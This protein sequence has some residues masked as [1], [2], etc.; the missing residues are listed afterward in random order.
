M[1]FCVNCGNQLAENQKFCPS[2]GTATG[3]AIPQQQVRSSKDGEVIKCPYCGAPANPLD[4][5]CPEC[6]YEFRNRSAA[7][8]VNDFF[9]HYRNASPSEKAAIIKAFPIPNAKEDI[10]TFLAMGIGNTKGLTAFEEAEYRN[11]D[12]IKSVL[13]G[14][15]GASALTY[16]KQEIAAWRAKVQ[17]VLDIGKLLIKDNES[18]ALFQK[19]EKQLKKELRK[20]ALTILKICIG[21]AIGVALIALM[22]LFLPKGGG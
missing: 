5:K 10:L 18:Q 8:S 11:R 15:S 13:T 22:M 7:K 1:T 9:E 3:G 17:Q 21:F 14:G 6:G 4:T 16:Q 19:Y 2:C 12:G 20:R